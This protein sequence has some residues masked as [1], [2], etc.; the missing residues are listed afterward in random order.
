MGTMVLRGE[1]C[2]LKTSK[3]KR[4]T[5]K[6]HDQKHGNNTATEVEPNKALFVHVA[7]AKESSRV[8]ASQHSTQQLERSQRNVP[9]LFSCPHGCSEACASSFLILLRLLLI[10][11][12]RHQWPGA[13]S[14]GAVRA[15]VT[16]V[17]APIAA[18]HKAC[19]K[20]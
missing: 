5:G 17:M 9:D 2:Y 10:P 3:K 13:T 4:K 6:Q 19:P 20:M 18:T 1:R 7:L 8:F 11:A 15:H 14:A 16:R 12:N